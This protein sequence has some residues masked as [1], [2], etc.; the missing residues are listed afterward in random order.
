[1]IL[2]DIRFWDAAFFCL[3]AMGLIAMLVF[4]IWCDHLAKLDLQEKEFILAC[5]K[6]E[7]PQGWHG[8][9]DGEGI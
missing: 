9:G 1:M 6:H 2:D 3:G 8:Y 7:H 4:A 5:R